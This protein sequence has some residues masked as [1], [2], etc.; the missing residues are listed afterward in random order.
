[1]KT[2]YEY[3][4]LITL[5]LMIFFLLYSVIVG[6]IKEGKTDTSKKSEFDRH[7]EDQEITLGEQK[8]IDELSKMEE[9]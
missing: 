8:I 2:A 4:F 3:I 1:M 9:L 6:Y 5:V 7:A